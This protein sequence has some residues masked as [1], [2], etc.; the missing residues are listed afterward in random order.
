MIK[1]ALSGFNVIDFTESIAGAHCTMMLADLGAKVIKVESLA[2]DGSLRKRFFKVKDVDPVFTAYNRNKKSISLNFESE[3]AKKIVQKLLANA[4][5][6]IVDSGSGKANSLG[7]NYEEIKEAFPRL[8]YTVI[9]PF[10]E[11]GPYCG[12]LM[13]EGTIQA[14]S[15]MSQSLLNDSGKAPYLV[16]GRPA[17]ISCAMV[18]NIAI[19]G[20]LHQLT[21]TGQGQKIV[22]NMYTACTLMFNFS[23]MDYLFNHVEK[24]V[25]GNAPNCFLK[26]KTGWIRVSCG[27]GPIW[28]RTIE[29]I[30][31]PFLNEDRFQ[32]PAVRLEHQSAIID[33]VQRWVEQYTSQE[34]MDLFTEKGIPC[35]K[36][37]TVEEL[38]D[39]EHLLDRKQVVDINVDGIGPLP[40]FANPC[41]LNNSPITYKQA[42]R[43]GE[44]TKEILS[45]LLHFSDAEI[46]AMENCGSI[47]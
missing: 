19:Q 32:D 6:A 24:P 27:D 37:R 8:I 47:G 22:S 11:S 10:G 33:H 9:T 38:K 29:L 25:D 34:V 3:D 26:T 14:E 44:N 2:G 45:E 16:G 41:K 20:A 1:K 23:I 36:V 12:R 43:L 17:E 15:G 18:T 30:G 28:N 35:G 46:S 4:E 42:P 7:L 5:V 13:F 39:N 31:D 21:L 40:Y